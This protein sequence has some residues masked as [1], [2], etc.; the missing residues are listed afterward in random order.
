MRVRVGVNHEFEV[1]ENV[2]VTPFLEATWGDPARY[3]SNY[4]GETDGHF[5]GGSL[6]FASAGFIS[7]WKFWDPFYLWLRY[8]QFVLVDPDARNLIED[9]DAPTAKKTYPVVGLGIG[10]RF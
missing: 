10:F 6:M 1:M 9:S 3:R 4:G 7:E 5:L 2:T 8:R